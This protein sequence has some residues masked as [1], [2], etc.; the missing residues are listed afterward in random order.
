ML[1]AA[2][3]ADQLGIRRPIFAKDCQVLK[4]AVTSN[5]YDAAPLGALFREI[6]YQL[7]LTKTPYGARA[8]GSSLS[9]PIVSRRDLF[10]SC[11]NV[12]YRFAS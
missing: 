3:L 4:T 9:S 10:R 1:Q 11:I 8:T 5:C 6:K 2:K 7:Q 12:L